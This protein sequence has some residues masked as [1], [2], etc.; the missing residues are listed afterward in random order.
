MPI[1]TS[2]QHRKS[3][4]VPPGYTFGTRYLQQLAIHVGF[5][6]ATA[7]GALPL[8]ESARQSRQSRVVPVFA[9]NRKA[10][11]VR[12][13][14]IA[15]HR[16]VGSMFSKLK[17]RRPRLSQSE[18]DMDIS[19]RRALEGR[20]RVEMPERSRVK[21]CERCTGPCRLGKQQGTTRASVGA[22]VR[23]LGK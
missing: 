14:G 6:Y 12:Y 21:V 9:P 15:R 22:I 16:K 8:W 10:V 17:R 13:P 11:C 4:F 23:A 3:C 2:C 18:C 7:M 5:P 1:S 20:P 19:M